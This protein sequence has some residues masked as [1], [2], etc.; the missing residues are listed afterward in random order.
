MIF[1][2]CGGIVFIALPYVG[3]TRSTEI[4]YLGGGLL[5][6]SV[7]LWIGWRLLMAASRGLGLTGKDGTTG[8]GWL[9]AVLVAAA[10]AAAAGSSTAQQGAS[11]LMDYVV[12][13]KRSYL[14]S[15]LG[16][17]DLRLGLRSL[18]DERFADWRMPHTVP[19]MLTLDESRAVAAKVMSHQDKFIHVDHLAGPLPFFTYGPYWGYH[20]YEPGHN[21]KTH[22]ERPTHAT[23]RT[24]TF[25][26]YPRAVKEDRHELEAEF[27]DVYAKLCA[28]LHGHLGG[29]SVELMPGASV[30][31]FHVIPSHLAW[32]FPVFRAHTDESFRSLLTAMGKYNAVPEEIGPPAQCDQESRISFTL[33]LSLPANGSGLNYVEY[34]FDNCEYG[35]DPRRRYLC[36][37]W[38]REVYEVGTLVIHSHG[39][40]HQIGEWPY[41]SWDGNRI[42]LQGFGFCCGRCAE[43]DGRWFLYW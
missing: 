27:G 37:K 43:G 15:E 19:H 3:Y 31:A 26:E 32:S 8:R 18:E 23:K 22:T 42:T 5:L 24:S 40:L 17:N 28:A 41:S 6:L 1:S 14:A 38:A 29:R 36:G 12:F 33:P 16:Q 34:D 20:H 35:R 25:L 39:L 30:P 11:K 4:M 21:H 2:C 13:M 7:V 10:L 9:V